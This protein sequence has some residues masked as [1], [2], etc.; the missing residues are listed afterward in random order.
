MR[1]QDLFRK[2]TAEICGRYDASEAESITNLLFESVAGLDRSSL[3]RK[4]KDEVDEDAQNRLRVAVERIMKG[5]PVQYVTGEA[6]FYGHKFRIRPGAL[7]PR[8]E[9]EE[10]VQLALE[11]AGKGKINILDIGTGSGC[12]AIS[13]KNALPLSSVTAIDI[14]IEALAI[15]RENAENL[16][17][18]IEFLQNDFLNEENREKLP[19]F[20]IIISNPPYIPQREREELDVHVREHE[21]AVALFVPDDRPM[22]FYEKIAEFASNHLS[23]NGLLL[24]EIHEPYA[25]GICDMLMHKGFKPEIRKDMFGKKRMIRASRSR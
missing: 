14:S 24:L 17:A 16:E 6:W 15:A 22:I 13:L 20:D 25:E 19:S 21:P 5:E 8:P 11:S 2:M 4:S 9:T 12:I 3:I 7:I 1:V 10:L 18:E 23:E